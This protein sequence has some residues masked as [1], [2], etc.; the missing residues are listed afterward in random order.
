MEIKDHSPSRRSEWNEFALA[1]PKKAM[2]RS[3]GN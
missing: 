1:A 3:K 2:S